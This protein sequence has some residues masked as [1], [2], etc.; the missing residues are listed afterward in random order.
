[1]AEPDVPGD[2]AA[3][4][5]P[6]FQFGIRS[7]LVLTTVCAV[8]AAIAASMRVPIVLQV[9]VAFWLMLM[10]TYAVLR[11]PYTC[12]RILRGRRRIR[13]QRS[14]L[15]ATVSEKRRGIQQARSAADSQQLPSSMTPDDPPAR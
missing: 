11:L 9:V 14:D 15:E 4:K 13:Q 8:A 7:V 6:P 2:K 10:A 1:M 12:R 3:Q 5:E